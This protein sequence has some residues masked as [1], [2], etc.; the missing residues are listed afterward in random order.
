MGAVVRLVRRWT[1]ASQTEVGQL[2]GMPQ[3]HVSELERGI[4]RVAALEVYERFVAGLGIPAELLGLA[5]GP[6][7]RV[8]QGPPQAAPTRS[9]GSASRIEADQDH[10]LQT[11]RLANRERSALTRLV[12]GLYP[13]EF[14]LW[15]TGIVM[16]QSWRPRV[17][18]ELASVG[19]SWQGETAAP[20][21]TGQEAESRPVRPLTR[22]GRPYRS[23]H[24]AVRDLDPPRLFENRLCYRLLGVDAFDDGAAAPR[25]TIGQMCYFDM[26]DIGEV[27]AHE[28]A[29]AAADGEGG[30]DLGGLAWSDLPMRRLIRNPLDLGRFPLLLS[31]STLT[32]RR[33]RAGPTFLMLRRDPAKVAIAGGMLSVIPTG[34]F[35]PASI[36]PA[37]Q[38][39]DFD[40]WRNVMREYLGNPE[41][42]GGG[43]PIDY[44]REEPFR[45]LEAAHRARTVRIFCLG[46]GIDCLN[47][48]ADVFTVAVFE[49]DVFDDLFAGMVEV[50]DEGEVVSLGERRQH[51][52]FDPESVRELLTRERVAP[53]GAA[54][55]TLAL[56]HRDFLLAAGT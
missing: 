50:N 20:T 15:D 49:A 23:Y 19:L 14:R 25:L 34:V 38:S 41:H 45:T 27:L 1:G 5:D 3:S 33:S 40:L 7:T 39:P 10:W 32:I 31:V 55:L 46:V 44:D 6:G 56:E 51:L 9:A 43:P 48:V 30:L 35:Q 36:L 52:G 26:I 13:P 11:R 12:A 4:R 24:R 21:V 42:D 17:P 37:P 2:V 53:S 18:I 28:A 22:N 8:D 54:C 47:Y 29:L 16:P